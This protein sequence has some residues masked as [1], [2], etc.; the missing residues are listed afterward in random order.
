MSSTH[1]LFCHLFWTESLV[2]IIS[3]QLEEPLEGEVDC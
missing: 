2:A 3:N 1:E